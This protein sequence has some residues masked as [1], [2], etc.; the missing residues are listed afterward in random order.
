MV[1][2]HSLD[3]DSLELFQWRAFSVSGFHKNTERFIEKSLQYPARELVR[4]CNCIYYLW[5]ITALHLQLLFVDYYGIAP[6][7][8]ICGLLRHC[9][10][11]Y[12][13][14]KYGIAP[15]VN[16]RRHITSECAKRLILTQGEIFTTALWK[17]IMAEQ[18]YTDNTCDRR[19]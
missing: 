17:L 6:A 4:N 15:A 8:I 16:F 18:L 14:D 2:R 5:I 11:I 10:C 12:F 13:D 9:T 7:V 1:V 19:M 3:S